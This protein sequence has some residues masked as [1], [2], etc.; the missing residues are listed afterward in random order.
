[1]LSV[2]LVGFGFAGRHLHAPLIRAAGMR[3]AAVVT[4]RADEVRAVLPD[5]DVIAHTSELNGRADVDLVV[6]ATPNHLHARQAAEALAAGKHVV[7]DKPMSVDVGE[8]DR[9]I[10]LA[11]ERNR[12]LSVFHNRRWDG[13]FLTLQQLISTGRLGE[14]QSLHLRWDRFRPEVRDRWRERPE[15]GAGVLYDLGSHLID[16]AL[17]LCGTSDWIYADVSAQRVGARADDAFEILMASGSTRV[18]LG[19]S[20]VA[21]DGGWRYRAHGLRGSFLKAGVDVQEEQLLAG[22]DPLDTRFGAEPPP[23]W[24]TFVGADGAREQVQS[25]PGAWVEFYRSMAR[26]IETGAAPPVPAAQSREVVRAIEA[27]LR[28]SREGRRVALR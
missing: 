5:A 4:Q 12:V 23:Q 21:A 24:G 10:A 3:I 26:S 20:S 7:V 25:L 8:A 1:M 9:L 6:V 18:T 17:R 2:G 14:L 15:P 16:Q 27:A 22:M 19:A 13:D 11:R 28:S